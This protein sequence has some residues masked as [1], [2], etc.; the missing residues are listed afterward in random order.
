[1][2]VAAAT[3]LYREGLARV[4]AES[5]RT[6]LVAATS[7]LPTGDELVRSKVEVLVLDAGS[8]PPEL[9]MNVQPVAPEVMKLAVGVSEDA[10]A[11]VRFAE[12]GVVGFVSREASVEELVAAIE[13][14]AHEGASCPPRLTAVLLRHLAMHARGRL[15]LEELLT[16]R[17]AE[18]VELLTQGRSNKEIAHELGIE[19]PTVKN[20]IH[21]ILEKL[22]VE[23]RTDVGPL[24]RS[25]YGTTHA[26]PRIGEI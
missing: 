6:T 8:V 4:V 26:S 24:V 10:S 21:N 16:A 17:E 11:L 14:V 1:M 23:R 12:A 9:L 22:Q 7:E 25:G 15:A 20:H 18:V 5:A 3:R 13:E 2:H 19:L